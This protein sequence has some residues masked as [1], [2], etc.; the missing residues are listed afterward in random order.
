MDRQARK[1]KEDANKEEGSEGGSDAVSEEEGE[2]KKMR[3]KMREDSIDP[4]VEG[5]RGRCE[6]CCTTA[7]GQFHKTNKGLL[8][9]TCH[10]FWK[11]TG[12]MKTKRQSDPTFTRHTLTKTKRKP[13]RGMFIDPEDLDSLAN[14]PPGTGENL[15]RSLDQEIVALK[16]LVQ[17]NKQI[18]SQTKHKVSVEINDDL[19]IPEVSSFDTVLIQFYFD[20]VLIHFDNDVSC[21]R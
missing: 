7:T 1:L 19:Q 11:K 15:L 18:V 14:G 17:N 16:R 6:N 9:N 10:S 20:T 21:F 12:T 8:C 2:E 4:R 5:N 13:P 3:E